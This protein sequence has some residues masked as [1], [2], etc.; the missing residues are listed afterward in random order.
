MTEGQCELRQVPWGTLPG[1]SGTSPGPACHPRAT[2]DGQPR[3]PADNHGHSY[4][5]ADLAVSCA[6]SVNASREHA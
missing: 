3:Y 4:P 2:P 1:S 6:T 5:T